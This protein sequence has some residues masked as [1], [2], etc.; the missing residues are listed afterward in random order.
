MIPIEKRMMLFT[1]LG[2]IKS[3][4]GIDRSAVNEVSAYFIESGG[5]ISALVEM[6]NRHIDDSQFH[7][8]KNILLGNDG[9]NNITDFGPE[10]Y[11]YLVCF[12]KNLMGREDFRYGESDD[13]EISGHHRIYERGQLQ[14]KPWYV[15]PEEYEK[16]GFSLLN[17]RIPLRYLRDRGDDPKELLEWFYSFMPDSEHKDA[18]FF[19]NDFYH[20][21]DEACLLFH[22]LFEAYCNGRTALED[23]FYRLY[24][25]PKISLWSHFSHTD[26]EM[27]IDS[28]LAMRK[29]TIASFREDIRKKSGLITWEI[30]LTDSYLEQTGAY[31]KSGIYIGFSSNMGANRALLETALGKRLSVRSTQI[32]LDGL[33]EYGSIYVFEIRYWR[34][35]WLAIIAL[36][37]LCLLLLV[38]TGRYI[39]DRQL[40]S[41]Y[42]M[43]NTAIATGIVVVASVLFYYIQRILRHNRVLRDVCDHQFSA[44]QTFSRCAEKNK[45]SG[46]ASMQVSKNPRIAKAL[47]LPGDSRIDAEICNLVSI[48][49]CSKEI[50]TRL[51]LSPRTIENR[52]NKIYK[53]MNVHSRT[54][55]LAKLQ[56][57]S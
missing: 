14:F 43:M 18:E 35:K 47:S 12:T 37:V 39:V 2:S 4:K 57:Y 16:K 8:T 40:F 19:E 1:P 15:L 26:S 28:I 49:L 53:R 41:P 48:G 56:T 9:Q 29:N 7:V 11:L 13:R 50:A 38:I 5:D 33:Q 46:D 30:R 34:I 52:L 51:C 22:S 20:L 27:A 24:A 31:R 21:S 23:C 42:I 32:F 54:E 45:S 3:G 36:S 10:F 25:S 17:V 6:L 55:L 44:F